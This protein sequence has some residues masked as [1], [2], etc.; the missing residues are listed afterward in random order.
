MSVKIKVSYTTDQELQEIVSL[1]SP[2]MKNVKIKPQKGKFKGHISHKSWSKILRNAKVFGAFVMLKRKKVKSV[3]INDK[4]N[5]YTIV[6]I[7]MHKER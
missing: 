6:R 4:G 3:L 5:A 1:L 7:S 2:V